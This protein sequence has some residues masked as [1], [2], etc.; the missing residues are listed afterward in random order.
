M[1]ASLLFDYITPHNCSNFNAYFDSLNLQCHNCDN[2]T[3]TSVDHLHCICPTGTIQV[4]GGT[5][6]KCE[7]ASK[8][9]FLSLGVKTISSNW[10][11]IF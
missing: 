3:V 1:H 2:G 10:V 5:C 11:D 8:C 9:D 6:Q 7:P 4:A